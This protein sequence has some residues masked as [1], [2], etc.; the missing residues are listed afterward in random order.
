MPERP[1]GSHILLIPDIESLTISREEVQQNMQKI[2]AGEITAVRLGAPFMTRLVSNLATYLEDLPDEDEI[3]EAAVDFLDVESMR[4]ASNSSHDILIPDNIDDFS[5]GHFYWSQVIHFLEAT[6]ELDFLVDPEEE[7]VGPILLKEV[8]G[9]KNFSRKKI[10][11]FDDPEQ[12]NTVVIDSDSK[13]P[14][15]TELTYA[16]NPDYD[17]QP[18]PEVVKMQVFA[19]RVNDILKEIYIRENELLGSPRVPLTDD[20][21][22]KIA[23]EWA[24]LR[25]MMI[26]VKLGVI[27]T[28]PEST[29]AVI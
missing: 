1:L 23:G 5:K 24:F 28:V 13:L 21:K 6:C 8:N 25:T 4:A 7:L 12:N 20:E 17:Q 27:P 15:L 16:M 14:L 26:G 18:D 10:M 9:R 29:S 3:K 19:K 22:R 11:T 2:E